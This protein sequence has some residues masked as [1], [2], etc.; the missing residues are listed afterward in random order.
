[1]EILDLIYWFL[2][3]I[4]IVYV[5]FV[6]FKFGSSKFINSNEL[7]NDVVINKTK[8]IDDLDINER[9]EFFELKHV[10]NKFKIC[11][12]ILIF[13]TIIYCFL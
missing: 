10:Y 7:Y 11:V 3:T 12:A 2:V 5:L 6:F 9:G 13:L 8:L 4:I 1:M